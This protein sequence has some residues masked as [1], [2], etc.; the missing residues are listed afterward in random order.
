MALMLLLHVFLTTATAGEVQIAVATNFWAPLQ[1][2]VTHFE[3]DT[4]HTAL[5][6]SG[7]TGKFYAQIKQDA[8][9]DVFFSADV[10]RPQLLED[11]GLTVP[12]SRFTYAVGRLT[13]WSPNPT[14]INGDGKTMLSKSDFTH[15]AIANP[16]TAPYGTA[17]KQA[18][19]VLGVWNA[20]KDRIVQGENI[21]QTFHFVVSQN[22]QLGFVALSQVL[23]PKINGAG[24]RWD[25]PTHLHDSL[26]QQAVLLLHGRNNEAAKAFLD[27]VKGSKSREIIAR[28]GYELE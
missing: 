5:I 7:S 4:E 6:S 2:I 16:K 11:E 13:L 20:V 28:F 25:V 15:L 3:R 12:G 9:F 18:L 24:S 10:R 8:P 1:E 27:Y 23:H 17:A 21:G 19:Q 26:Q 14:R 22:A